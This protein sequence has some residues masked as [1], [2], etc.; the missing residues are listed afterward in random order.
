MTEEYAIKAAKMKKFTDMLMA[1]KW[2]YDRDYEPDWTTARPKY[3]IV[4]N[5]DANP[6]KRYYIS[7]SYEY[8]HNTIYFSSEDIAK[9]CVDWLNVI[10]PDGELIA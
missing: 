2:C 5:Y 4:Y 9:K 1:F 8:R 3:H 6:N 7:M 10:D